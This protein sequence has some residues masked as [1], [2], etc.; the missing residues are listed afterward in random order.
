[1][2]FAS[3][4]LTAIIA[5]GTAFAQLNGDGYYRVQNYI[6]K[7]YV[8]VTDDKG[9]LDY[10]TS[11]ADM[12][13]IQLWKGFEKAS[14]D[15]ATVCYIKQVG[16]QY[17][18]LAQGTGIH[19][20]IDTYVNLRESGGIYYA[21][22]KKDSFIKYLSD[23]EKG[24]LDEG[25]MSDAGS[26]DY[27]KWH[28][29]PISATSENYFGIKAEISVGG[30]YYQPFFAEF[31]FSFASSGMNAYYI[32]KIGH[33]MAV[34]SEITGT[35][36]AETPVFIKASTASPATNKLNIGG[37]ASAISG[38]L[39]KGVYFNNPMKLHYNRVAYDSKT[40]R[41]LGVTSDGSIG[42]ITP[43][44]LDFI[45]AN[46][47]YLSVP[48]G[49]PAELKIVTEEEY[50]NA[51][52]SQPT[53]ITLNKS[54]LSLTE[55]ETE[56]LVAAIAPENADKTVSWT[57]SDATVASVSDEGNVT[58]KKAGNATITA[59]TTNG[60]TAKCEV[61]VKSAVVLATSI[62]IDKATF[63]AEEGTEFTLL[64]TILPENVTNKTVKWES[65]DPTVV[66]VSQ[67]GVAKVIA[68][69]T[70]TITVSTTDGTNL[71]ASCQVTGLAGIEDI[72]NNSTAKFNVYS[73]NGTIVKKDATTSDIKA[74][75]PGL[76]IIGNEKVLIK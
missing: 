17:D 36:P 28:I 48:E 33:G 55:G 13:A 58:A 35:I 9:R 15:P 8:Y 51:I 12:Y 61:T 29:T 66:T 23:G 3:L 22:G 19:E 16:T 39:L 67:N 75:A 4:F 53:G 74:L 50:N 52:A 40:M 27:R 31:P 46:T 76:Y 47:A 60:L 56:S 72:L 49:T 73:V 70:A 6:T 34:M 18:I 20:I 71:S 62:A 68:K 43:A 69:G 11:S 42:Y 41:I 57:S 1:M 65:S 10:A 7:R 24:D 54:A 5:T 2:K 44:S 59:T 38:N 21:Y 25:V 63:S 30:N 14:S 64:A 32:S 26:G 37:T 45:P